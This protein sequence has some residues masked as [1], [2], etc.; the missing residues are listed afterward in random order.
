VIGEPLD[1]QTSIDICYQQA[2]NLRVMCI[3]EQIHLLL[4]ISIGFCQ[5]LPHSRGPGRPVGLVLE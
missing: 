5:L 2:K 4:L 3:A 1:C